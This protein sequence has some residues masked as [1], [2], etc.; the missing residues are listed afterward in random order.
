M[1]P[2]SPHLAHVRWLLE[3][4]GC[5]AALDEARE[6]LEAA[7][8]AEELGTLVARRCDGE[9][10]AWVTGRTT[11]CD[12]E[13]RVEPG[14]YVPRWQSEPLARAAAARLPDGGVGVDL[15]TGSGAIAMVLAAGQPGAQVVGTDVD[16]IAVR[17]ARTNGV[18]AYQG[19]LDEGLPRELA[20][21]V[22]VLTAVVPYVPRAALGLLPRDVARFEPRRALDGGE[23]GLD[24]LRSVV[25]CSPR[26]LRPGGWLAVEVGMDQV[27]EARTILQRGGFGQLRALA[28]QDGDPRAVMGSYPGQGSAPERA[29]GHPA[30][31]TRVRSESSVQERS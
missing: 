25:A 4:A 20:G 10:L 1:D 13:V 11:F 23:T 8:D 22:D 3:K 14:V 19:D 18:R 17:C 31:P 29:G 21:R 7:A 12:L 27:V 30:G 6:L 9:P 26:W 28:D 5:V 16:P 2:G 24:V 15:C